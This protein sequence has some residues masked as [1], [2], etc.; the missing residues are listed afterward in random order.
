M[1][2]G[3]TETRR[4][5]SWRAQIIH[6]SDPGRVITVTAASERELDAIRMHYRELR[7][8]VRHG[9]KSPADVRAMLDRAESQQTVWAALDVYRGSLKGTTLAAFDTSTG[10]LMADFR[11]LSIDELDEPHMRAWEQ[12]QL[13]KGY[14][15]ATI[16]QAFE[17][18]RAAIRRRRASVPWGRFM[19]QRDAESARAYEKAVSIAEVI[20]LLEAACDRDCAFA[21]TTGGLADLTWRVV[22]MLLCG[23]RKGEA[24]GLSWD[25]IAGLDSGRSASMRIDAQVIDGWRK[26][27]P[28]WTR[29]LDRPKGKRA[30]TIAIHPCA[31]IV[32]QW[33]QDELRRRGWYRYDGP[34]FPGVG[35]AWRECAE[36]I[37]WATWRAMVAAAKMPNGGD[38]VVHSLRHSMASLEVAGGASVDDVRRRTGH[39]SISMVLRYV[40]STGRHLPAS[41]IQGGAVPG[42]GAELPREERSLV[43]ALL[44]FRLRIDAAAGASLV[45]GRVRIA[46]VQRAAALSRAGELHD[47]STAELARRHTKTPMRRYTDEATRRVARAYNDAWSAALRRGATKE[48]ARD[49]GRTAR[50]LTRKVWDRALARARTKELK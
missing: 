46:R 6:P 3:Q 28:D 12:A 36:A 8:Q 26:A 15:P 45:A 22:V 19:V 33:Q 38:W 35:G 23:L 17:F 30:R 21:R 40:A 50:A 31:A 47:V 43:D 18:L 37:R 48:V 49:E 14:A 29:P 20:Q 44:G 1:S 7:R 32:L 27:H 9:M 16:V 39:A 25:R 5:A 41:R 4:R 2:E 10:R 34:V 24:A 13:T 11:A 42:D